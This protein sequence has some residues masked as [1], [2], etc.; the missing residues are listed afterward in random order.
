MCNLYRMTR[1]VDEI[2]RLFQVESVHGANF[3]ADV[4]PGYTGL[5]VADGR[6]RSMNWGFPLILTGRQGQKLKPKPVTNAR[7]DK[8]QTAFWRDSFA[9]RRCLI[10]MSQW[11]EPEGRDRRMTRTWYGLPHS[12]RCFRIAP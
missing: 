5:V 2:A 8:L 9:R 7:D 11:A 3:S 6:V 1:G 12:P 10:P 4:Y